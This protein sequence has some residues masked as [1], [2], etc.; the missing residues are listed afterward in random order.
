MLNTKIITMQEKVI[1][2]YLGSDKIVWT[3][4]EDVN[5]DVQDINK[6]YALK[7]FGIS[8]NNLKQVFDFKQNQY[9]QVGNQVKYETEQYNVKLVNKEMSRFSNSNHIFAIISKVI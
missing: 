3:D 8:G 2:S 5:C 6:E 4:I 7:K 1:T 9:W